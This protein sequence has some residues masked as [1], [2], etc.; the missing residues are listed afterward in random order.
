MV[1]RL[2]KTKNRCGKNTSTAAVLIGEPATLR[3]RSIEEQLY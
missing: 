2:A 3:N 1:S